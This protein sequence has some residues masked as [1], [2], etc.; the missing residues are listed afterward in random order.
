MGKR[1]LVTGIYGQDGAYLAKLLL[2]KGYEVI[3][4]ARRTS[5]GGDWR[6]AELG[7]KGAFPVVDFELLEYSN[8][9]RMVEK[10]KADEIYNLAAQSF[11][12]VSF[13][14]PI[15]TAEADALGVARLLEAIRTV[16]SGSRFYQASTSE[17]FGREKAG[18][19]NEMTP[20]HPCSPYAAAKL[21]AYWMTA[22]YRDGYGMYACS[23]ILFN[24]ESP[25]RGVEFVTRKITHTL[26]AIKR[27]NANCLELGNLHTRRDWGYAGDY[28]EAM[29]LML[30]Q[31]KADDFVIA[32]G[33]T[34]S[35]L[36]F[37]NAAA[38][39][40]GFALEWH[41]TDDAMEAIDRRTGKTIIRVNPALFRPLDVPV[42]QGDA[43]KAKEKL[44]WSPR[45]PFLEVVE[46]MVEADLRR[47]A[48]GAPAQNKRAA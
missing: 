27:G 23:G 13:E 6:L 25:L 16:S 22:N 32:T 2:Q 36:D 30:Q 26:A 3:G 46:M 14:E 20:F 48:D 40:M 11:V 15:Y 24:H 38:P 29:H 39:M 37:V 45:T 12:G 8:I 41:G 4:A 19:Q 18:A 10:T 43:S 42:L 34:R 1:A 9:F 5:S 47:V 35:T 21:Y 28:V 17:L 31:E 7:I 44:G 33:E